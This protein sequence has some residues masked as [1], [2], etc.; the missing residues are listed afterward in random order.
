MMQQLGLDPEAGQA[1]AY[2]PDGSGAR[3]SELPG[4]GSEAH[5]SGEAAQTLGVMA[6]SVRDRRA[7]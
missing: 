6:Q 2:P 7:P 1:E 4:S 5:L 3:Q